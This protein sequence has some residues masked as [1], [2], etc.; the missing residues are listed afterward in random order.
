MTN[1]Q[2]HAMRAAIAA[3]RD[4]YERID[5]ISFNSSNKIIAQTAYAILVALVEGLD[6]AISINGTGPAQE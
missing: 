6:A 4:E 3:R 1:E 5:R 2:L